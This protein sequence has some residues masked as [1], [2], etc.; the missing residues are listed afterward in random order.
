MSLK[1]AEAAT[2]EAASSAIQ[3]GCLNEF[4]FLEPHVNHN[5]KLV[6]TFSLRR[7]AI[8]L[9]SMRFLVA[10]KRVHVQGSDVASTQ[11]V[12]HPIHNQPGGGHNHPLQCRRKETRLLHVCGLLSHL[13]PKLHGK[14]VQEQSEWLKV[15]SRNCRSAIWTRLANG[16]PAAHV[17]RNCS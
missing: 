5:P 11:Y 3:T 8:W 4:F 7:I 15:S 14:F 16:R 6:M 9:Q 1:S 10:K 13:E 17:I 2:F 12:L